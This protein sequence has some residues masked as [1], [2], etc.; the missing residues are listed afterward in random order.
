[1]QTQ[2]ALEAI[3]PLVHGYHENPFEV[4]GPHAGLLVPADDPPAL[5]A[6][7]A[8]LLD[9]PALRAQLA[10]GALRR[11]R[12]VHRLLR[13]RAHALL[14]LDRPDEAREALAPVVE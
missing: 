9:D 1:M 5:A 11:G 13:Q 7:L 8:S 4:L 3:G 12:H 14:L 6:A 2:V 10:R